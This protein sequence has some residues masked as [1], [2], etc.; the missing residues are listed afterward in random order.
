M[1]APLGGK[2]V[3]RPQGC[4]DLLLDQLPEGF[5]VVCSICRQRWLARAE[6]RARGIRLRALPV[7]RIERRCCGGIVGSCGDVLA[8]RACCKVGKGER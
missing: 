8:F 3:A 6:R 1:V 2:I 5:G 4:Y 7:A